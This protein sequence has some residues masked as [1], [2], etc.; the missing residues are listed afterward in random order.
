MRKC[1]HA[2]SLVPIPSPV[3][4]RVG[5]IQSEVSS[6]AGAASTAI[7]GASQAGECALDSLEGKANSS[8]S[9]VYSIGLWGYC[10][11]QVDNTRVDISKCSSPQIGFWFDFRTLLGLASSWEEEIFQGKLSTLINVYQ[12]VST[13]MS[14]FYITAI[15]STS[16]ALILRG[17]T[18]YWIFPG[19]LITFCICV[20][21]SSYSP[22]IKQLMSLTDIHFIKH[23]R[24]YL[25]NGHVQFYGQYPELSCHKVW[26][27]LCIWT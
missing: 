25:G 18:A 13:G 22:K 14:A 6:A 3:S 11:G 16:L 15:I 20:S 4:T 9:D 2:R 23:S 10:E 26:N 21:L 5:S 12:K 1:L 8:L 27:T 24:F 7:G 17:L 19:L